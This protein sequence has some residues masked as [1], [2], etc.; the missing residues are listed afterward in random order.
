[1]IWRIT[2]IIAVLLWPS[3]A[4]SQSTQP[5]QITIS[6]PQPGKPLE[7]R[8]LTF[9]PVPSE[10]LNLPRRASFSGKSGNCY[11]TVV[12]AGYKLPRTENGWAGT[13]PVNA[14]KITDGQLAVVVT[15]EGPHG[16]VLVVRQVQGKLVSVI[17]GNYPGGGVGRIVPPSV[18]KGFIL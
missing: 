2:L 3:A 4:S 16:H 12:S 15:S 14:N 7:F 18:V 6:Y 5:L 17:E 8:E 13:L 11:T 1:M 9:L 10:R